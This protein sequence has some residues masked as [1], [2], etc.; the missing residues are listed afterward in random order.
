M[1]NPSQPAP[2]ESRLPLIDWQ[3]A[4]GTM[5][6]DPKLLRS[7]V[8]VLM[9]EAPRQLEVMF[10]AAERGDAKELRIV[11]H[12]LKS[13]LRYFGVESASSLAQ[14]IEDSAQLGDAKIA[15]DVGEQL[16]EAV[17]SVLRE[18]REFQQSDSSKAS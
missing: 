9:T 14:Q 12:A 5:G 10:R 1:T 16:R 11:A 13:S 8:P 3:I 2:A 15:D 18:L 17:A 7:L 6:G 4:L